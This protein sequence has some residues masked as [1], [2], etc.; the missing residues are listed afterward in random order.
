[1]KLIGTTES[2]LPKIP[3][4]LKGKLLFAATYPISEEDAIKFGLALKFLVEKLKADRIINITNVNAVFTEYGE[5]SLEM[6]E[7]SAGVHMGLSVYA[8]KR[9]SDFG[10]SDL[11]KILVFLE[12]LCHHYWR[13]EDE[14]KVKYIVFDIAKNIFPQFTN[15]EQVYNFDTL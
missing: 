8:V 11:Q 12:E 15:I 3:E 1:M 14:I 10:F 6:N 2:Y 7:S 4:E 9:W 5:I 13:E